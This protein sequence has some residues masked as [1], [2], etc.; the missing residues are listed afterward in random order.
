M[1]TRQNV[2]NLHW[3]TR[4]TDLIDEFFSEITATSIIISFLKNLVLVPPEDLAKL[5]GHV[6]LSKL[7]LKM[8]QHF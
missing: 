7:R 6:P 8:S 3:N 2:T 4:H 5:A 1:A